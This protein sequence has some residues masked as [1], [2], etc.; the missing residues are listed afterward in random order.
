MAAIVTR[1][2]DAGLDSSIAALYPAGDANIKTI[3]NDIGQN[4]AGSPEGT[5]KPRAEYTVI[6]G[7]PL[8]RSRNSRLY[9]PIATIHVRG[10]TAVQVADFV[11]AI[12]AAFINSEAADTD[13]LTTSTGDVLDVNDGGQ[14]VMKTDDATFEGEQMLLIQT[15]VNNRRPA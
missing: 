3:A 12:G 2:N 9:Q 13:P 10:T 5:A 15:R 1:W 14:W 8:A 7:A 11:E 6:Q 4:R